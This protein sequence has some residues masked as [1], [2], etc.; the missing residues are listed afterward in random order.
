MSKYYNKELERENS[1]QEKK[2]VY[3]YTVPYL[4][5]AP[6]GMTLSSGST[7]GNDLI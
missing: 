2:P 1:F 4:V 3:W 5:A 7:K 6:R